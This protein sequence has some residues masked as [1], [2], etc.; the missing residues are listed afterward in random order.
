MDEIAGGIFA[1]N[2]HLGARISCYLVLFTRTLTKFANGRPLRLLS[3]GK[4]PKQNKETHRPKEENKWSILNAI[5]ALGIPQAVC[6]SRLYVDSLSCL[7]FYLFCHG[8][9]FCLW[10]L[11]PFRCLSLQRYS[12]IENVSAMRCFSRERLIHCHWRQEVLLFHWFAVSWG[13]IIPGLARVVYEPLWAKISQFILRR[14]HQLWAN[15]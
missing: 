14:I 12:E 13:E 3:S 8:L 1:A 15:L 6:L 4:I 5:K 10:L 11:C 2:A 7:L 9:F